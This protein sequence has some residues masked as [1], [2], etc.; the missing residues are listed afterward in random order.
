MRTEAEWRRWLLR[1]TQQWTTNFSDAEDIM[2]EA[3]LRFRLS[4]NCLPWE[5]TDEAFAKAVCRCLIR[6]VASEF[7]RSKGKEPDL[8]SLD[9]LAT[10]VLTYSPEESVLD[11]LACRE[12]LQ[13]LYTMLSPQQVQVLALLEQG[14]THSEIGRLMGIH[15]GTVKRHYE[16]ICQK[17]VVLMST[18]DYLSVELYIGGPNDAESHQRL[19]ESGT[20]PNRETRGGGRSGADAVGIS[21]SLLNRWVL[22]SISIAYLSATL[23]LWNHPDVR[24]RLDRRYFQVERHE[25]ANPAGCSSS[26]DRLSEQEVRQILRVNQE[27][28]VKEVNR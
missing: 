22:I 11:D 17:A 15:T 3:L 5:H 19:D 8:V 26:T 24:L 27:K 13:Q 18:K 6:F 7:Y 2:Q 4:T 23:L 12:F 20:P 28:A 14:Y 21:A 10:D 9:T 25:L 1:L 16:R